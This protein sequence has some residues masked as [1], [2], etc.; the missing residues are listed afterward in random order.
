MEF[1]D[2]LNKVIKRTGL[3][4]KD[5]SAVCGLTKGQIQKYLNGSQEPKMIFF[6]RISENFPFINIEWLITGTGIIEKNI[7]QGEGGQI[8]K[9]KPVVEKHIDVVKQF[10]DHEAAV[11]MNQDLVFIEKKSKTKFEKVRSYIKGMREGLEDDV[12]VGHKKKQ[13]DRRKNNTPFDHPE[14][15]KKAG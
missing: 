4:N 7:E 12:E 10:D 3:K 14:R 8:V 1:K 2:R 6:N 9:L 13:L 5:F 11:D 15:R